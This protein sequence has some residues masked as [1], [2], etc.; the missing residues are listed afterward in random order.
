MKT[1][2]PNPLEKKLLQD[3]IDLLKQSKIKFTK[4]KFPRGTKLHGKLEHTRVT[5]HVYNVSD[6]G[7]G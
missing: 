3:I 7:K 5:F 2:Y 4:Q 6:G 1:E